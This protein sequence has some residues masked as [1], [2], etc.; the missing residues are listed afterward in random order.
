MESA[1]DS[2]ATNSAQDPMDSAQ[3]E[4]TASYIDTSRTRQLHVATLDALQAHVAVL[5]P[6]ATIIT[7]N[8]AWREAAPDL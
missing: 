1:A 7:V 5:D 4:G 3:T 6:H 8:R 2:G